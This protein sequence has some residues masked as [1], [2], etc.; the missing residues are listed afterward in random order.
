MALRPVAPVA[1]PWHGQQPV[2]APKR[3]PLLFA[4]ATAEDIVVA[5]AA[6]VTGLIGA[7]VA[8]RFWRRRGGISGAASSSDQLFHESLNR[9]LRKLNNGKQRAADEVPTF[10]RR[11]PRRTSSRSGSI[12]SGLTG[13]VRSSRMARVPFVARMLGL[14]CL[15]PPLVV[16]V[17]FGT[18][19][20][21][22]SALLREV[23]L[24]PL[25]PLVR[26]YYGSRLSSL[27]M[28]AGLYGLVG[29]NRSLHPFTRGLGMQ[30]STL[31]MMQFPVAILLQFIAPA[32]PPVINLA[33]GTA[34][35]RMMAFALVSL[36]CL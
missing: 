21:A 32:P 8:G 33:T 10:R 2:L 25:L 4:D 12:S 6:G 9:E 5:G 20:F 16:A 31:M 1:T 22:Q 14:A 28:I 11:P 23:M 36:G 7:A 15:V 26:A 30:A 29:K 24:R 17:P 18:G 34:S 13:L 3:V 27:L 19:L 35:G